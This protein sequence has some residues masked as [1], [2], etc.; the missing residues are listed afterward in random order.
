MSNAAV[1]NA[2]DEGEFWQGSEGRFG[3]VLTGGTPEKQK[4]LF[5]KRKHVL[6][7]CVQDRLRGC[8]F[9]T[10]SQ[11]MF[12]L[13]LWNMPRAFPGFFLWQFVRDWLLRRAIQQNC[14]A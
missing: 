6:K 2:S 9:K 1:F 12:S 3:K 8:T 7:I 4:G 10:P 13:F 11:I 14:P 5:K